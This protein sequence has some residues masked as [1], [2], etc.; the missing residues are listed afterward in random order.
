MSVRAEVAEKLRTDWADIPA[1]ED[2]R[3]V[4]RENT[5]DTPSVPTA[6]IRHKSITRS[7]HA[8]MS[9]RDVGLLLTLISP[10]AD[11]DRAM[12]QLEDLADAAL[13]YLET[14]DFRHGE[15]TTADWSDARL[16]ID[17]PLT[18]FAKKEQE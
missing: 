11:L 14:S 7:E 12:D 17:I 18:V 15:A 6:L 8:P 2:V 9:H 1:L 16:S 13:D 10:H 5:L 4:A 3:V